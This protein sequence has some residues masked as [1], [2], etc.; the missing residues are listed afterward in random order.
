M[1][2]LAGRRA[3]FA[4]WFALAAL[5]AATGLAVVT[6]TGKSTGE[7]VVFGI[8]LALTG[9]AGLL[10]AVIVRRWLPRLRLR[11]QLL[12]AG[13]A[14]LVVLV[15]NVA[16]ASALMLLDAH[17]LRLL[18]VLSAYALVTTIG[19]AHLLGRG[20]TGR[21]EGIEAA[22][23]RLA[24]GE[25]GA[26]VPE[27]GS[28]EVANLAREFNR[29]ADALQSA[30]TQRDRVERSRRDLFAAI[31]HDLRTPL[32]SIRVM[33]EAMQDGVVDDDATR[34]RYLATASH[35]VQRLS[36]LIDDLFELTTLD[37]GELQLRVE[38]LHVEDIVAEAVDTFRPQVERAG[39]QLAVDAAPTPAILADHQRLARVL[40]N[41]IQN[42]LRH[43]PT[44]GSIVLRT[45]AASGHVEVTVSDTG[46]GIGSEDLGHVFERF[47]RGDQSRSR[48]TGGSGLGLAIVRGIVEAHG[49]SVRVESRPGAGST[50]TVSLPAA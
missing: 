11:T 25:L 31:S 45:A 28:D 7:C 35:E 4:G 16:V 22:A 32:A 34:T 44:D 15:T 46:S 36:L 3:S 17:D 49:G 41:L 19:P 50:F 2:V 10:L 14:G 47:Y 1:G 21:I 39:I 5:M 26:R 9:A 38:R 12:I 18:A 29:M 8:A 27:A 37:S 48:E 13:G 33:V 43:T 42:A 23:R 24:T 40:A 30:N 6:S 20:L